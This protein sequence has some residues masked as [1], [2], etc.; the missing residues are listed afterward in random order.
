MPL[1]VHEVDAR[2]APDAGGG[3]ETRMR[4]EEFQALVAAVIRE[5][6]KRKQQAQLMSSQSA[7]TG[8]NQPPSVGI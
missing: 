4:P 5:L 2:V 8:Q 1:Y 6:D 7:I 3:G